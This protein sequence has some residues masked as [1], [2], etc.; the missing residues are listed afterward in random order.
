MPEMNNSPHPLASMLPTQ[1]RGHADNP[2][3][4]LVV[5]IFI[6]VIFA[7]GLVATALGLW[8]GRRRIQ[9]E[10]ACLPTVPDRRTV[11]RRI[12]IF[13]AAITATEQC[14]IRKRSSSVGSVATS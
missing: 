10:E 2:Y 6:P 14:N 5:F 1:I 11:I 3:V 7:L 13:F 4:R 12:A 9:P 8:L